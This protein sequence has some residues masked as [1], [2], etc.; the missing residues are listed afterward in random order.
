MTPF[1]KTFVLGYTNF[2]VRSVYFIGYFSP[3]RYDVTNEKMRNKLAYGRVII[4]EDSQLKLS[5]INNKFLLDTSRTFQ[6]PLITHIPKSICV[7]GEWVNIIDYIDDEKEGLESGVNSDIYSFNPYNGGYQVITSKQLEYNYIS[8]M[9]CLQKYIVIRVKQQLT[10]KLTNTLLFLNPQKHS[11]FQEKLIGSLT[12]EGTVK[13]RDILFFLSSDRIYVRYIWYPQEGSRPQIILKVVFLKPNFYVRF[14]AEAKPK[15]VKLS[16][17]N[18][19]LRNHLLE[20]R[21]LGKSLSE[22]LSQTSKPEDFIPDFD[23]TYE[24]NAINFN[25][26]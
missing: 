6:R 7:T 20:P 16:P 26:T 23:K 5:V 19:S 4:N 14:A 25:S 9:F 24:I 2:H 8:R 11:N 10:D 18:E 17:Q 1:F 21:L 15:P 22:S 3:E 12:I 13:S